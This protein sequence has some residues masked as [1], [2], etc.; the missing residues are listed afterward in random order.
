[1]GLLYASGDSGRSEW[2]RVGARV[3]WNITLMRACYIEMSLKETVRPVKET[4]SR[5][6]CIRVRV[7]ML[8]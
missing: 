7:R 5:K 6:E 4:Q 1:M 2:L 8:C 3:R